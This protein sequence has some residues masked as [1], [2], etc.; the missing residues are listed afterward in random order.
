MDLLRILLAILVFI[1]L[2]LGQIAKFDLGSAASITAFDA[3]LFILV[4]YWI[5]YSIIKKRK[6]KAKLAKPILVFILIGLV[7]LLL[8]TKELTWEQFLVSFSYLVRWALY[9]ASYFIVTDFGKE[10]KKKLIS[11]IFYSGLIVLFLGF[12]QVFFYPSLKNLY[13]LGWDEHMYR[14]FST[15]L[16]P[17][18]TG[19]YLVVIFFLGIYLYLS[20]KR[21][22]YIVLSSLVLVGI[23]LTY[24]RTAFITLLISAVS[25]L[26]ILNR[27]RLIAPV[28]VAILLI[29]IVFPKTFKSEG[30]NFFR[31]FSANARISTMQHGLKIFS[32]RPIFGVGFN[33]Y[34]YFQEKY[35]FELTDYVVPSRAAAGVENSFI[36]VLATTGI[37]GFIFYLYLLFKIFSLVFLSKNKVLSKIT[38]AVLVGLIGSSMFINSLFYTFIMFLMWTLIGVIESN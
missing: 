23:F 32:D 25:L 30:T 8:N 10:E 15:F 20:E 14:L 38:I 6:I 27:K 2:P 31:T 9:A 1:L 28:V 33:S 26:I 22:I 18:F 7:S 3:G 21:K 24:S 17:N 13:Y 36:L 37:I 19:I 29:A 4:V 16:D 5:F 12:V 35:G 11:Y 34:R